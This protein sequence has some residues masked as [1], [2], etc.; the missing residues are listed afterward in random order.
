[1]TIKD[2]DV[3]EEG[4]YA[5]EGRPVQSSSQEVVH[6]GAEAADGSKNSVSGWCC[7]FWY[8]IKRVRPLFC[9][10]EK[11][12]VERWKFY[13]CWSFTVSGRASW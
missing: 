4:K 6:S 9:K 5:S 11:R 10:L 12:G 13:S 7:C 3:L 1:M 2:G 8:T